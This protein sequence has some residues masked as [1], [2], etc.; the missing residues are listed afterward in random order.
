MWKF[1]V[2]RPIVPAVQVVTETDA[3]PIQS[4]KK[5][6]PMF[7]GEESEKE[8]FTHLSVAQTLWSTMLISGEHAN[9]FG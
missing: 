9:E 8:G 7:T 2:P 3:H 6:L 1:P 5:G 4:Q